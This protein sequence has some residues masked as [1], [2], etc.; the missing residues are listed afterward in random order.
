MEEF[1]KTFCYCDEHNQAKDDRPKKF[2]ALKKRVSS[3][4]GI[5]ERISSTHKEI[6]V[7]LEAPEIRVHAAESINFLPNIRKRL[8]SFGVFWRKFSL[9]LI[10]QSLD[11]NKLHSKSSI[12]LDIKRRYSLFPIKSSN[13]IK[14]S[15]SKNRKLSLYNIV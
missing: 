14:K 13:N 15:F 7:N 11:L 1:K 3:L 8:P 2:D 4:I 6:S 9:P 12:C 5:R 10:A